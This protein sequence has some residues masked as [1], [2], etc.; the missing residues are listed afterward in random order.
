MIIII[1]HGPTKTEDA[2]IYLKYIQY[3]G[4]V[5]YASISGNISAKILRKIEG[6]ICHFYTT[7]EW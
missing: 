6:N 3:T 2:D 1:W 7:S 4:L 5:E